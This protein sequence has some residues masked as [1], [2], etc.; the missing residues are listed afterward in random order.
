MA[1]ETY[2]DLLKRP[3]FHQSLPF[4]PKASRGFGTAV[5]SYRFLEKASCGIESCHQ[6]HFAGYLITTSDGLETVIGSYCGKKYFGLSFTREK[7]RVDQEAERAR[8]INLISDMLA[9]MPRF[10]AVIGSL[11]KSYSELRDQKARL[12]EV[13]GSSVYAVLK[14]R[15]D[16]DER[17]ITRDVPM[18]KLEAESYFETS[19]RKASDSRGWPTKQV[20]LATL[21]GLPFIKAR[22][23]DML[24]VGLIHPIRELSKTNVSTVASM[25]PKALREMAKWVGEVPQDILKAQA[26]I[27]AGYRF[28][29]AEN[30]EKL[31]HLGAN[32]T[33]MSSMI[34]DLQ[35]GRP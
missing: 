18:T 22:F 20:H 14:A 7:K 17:E 9:D 11:E 21:D 26:I 24:V 23:K 5:E 16:R 33:A 30:I 31:V 32:R 2:E 28:F 34:E 29:T 13:I 12:M 3:N 1:I 25:K 15:A 27:D 8:R 35:K 19:N 4:H 10:L 6:A